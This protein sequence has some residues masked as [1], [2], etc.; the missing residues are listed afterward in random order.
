M[1]LGLST[2]D[3]LSISMEKSI[4]IIKLAWQ[5]DLMITIS[6]SLTLL[7]LVPSFTLDNLELLFKIVH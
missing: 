2:Q 7:L 3:N 6:Y 4:K 1:C 5:K